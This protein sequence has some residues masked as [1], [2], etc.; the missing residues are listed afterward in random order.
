MPILFEFLFHF[1]SD[2][3]WDVFSNE[4]AVAAMRNIFASG[5]CTAADVAG[6]MVDIAL[7]RGDEQND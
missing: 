2:G 1:R 7:R 6:N 5:E 4:A 3:L